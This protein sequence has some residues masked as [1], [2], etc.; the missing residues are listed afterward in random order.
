MRTRYISELNVVHEGKGHVA[1]LVLRGIMKAYQ[2]WSSSPAWYRAWHGFF[3]AARVQSCYVVARRNRLRHKWKTDM[4]R[5]SR[6]RLLSRTSDARGPRGFRGPSYHC[7][8]EVATWR[9]EQHYGLA[10][11]SAS[12][13]SGTGHWTQLV[14]DS[15]NSFR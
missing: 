11:L 13:V 5:P 10:L 6:I 1:E 3:V 2:L 4:E 15:S 12:S 9:L 8:S 7:L 14:G